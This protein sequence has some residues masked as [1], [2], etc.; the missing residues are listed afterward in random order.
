[1]SVPCFPSSVSYITVCCL[2]T[3]IWVYTYLRAPEQSAGERA[4]S[5]L[6][7]HL[8]LHPWLLL[9]PRPLAPDFFFFTLI[10]FFYIFYS[11][12]FICFNWL[13]LEPRPLSLSAADYMR[14]MI[15]YVLTTYDV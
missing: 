13:L 4:R 6:A 12:L 5:P 15:R 11:F 2:I 8:Q 3:F 1:M 9:E 14:Y 10:Y 7:L